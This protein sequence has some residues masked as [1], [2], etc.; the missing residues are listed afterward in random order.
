MIGCEKGAG[1]LSC[2]LLAHGAAATVTY[3]F[4]RFAAV[5]VR[6]TRRCKASACT[7]LPC[8]NP[9]MSVQK[10]DARFR[11]RAGDAE[12]AKEDTVLAI[13]RDVPACAAC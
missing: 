12:R 10:G 1:A 6:A 5:S 3:A 13:A 11:R 4:G 8:S 7:R 9:F 2:R